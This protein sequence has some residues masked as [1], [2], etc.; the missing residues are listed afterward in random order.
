MHLACLC[1]GQ[2]DWSGFNFTS[3]CLCLT[4]A[5]VN[6]T[7]HRSVAQVN[8]CAR[9]LHR[10]ISQ[11]TG[12]L[13]RSKRVPDLCTGQIHRLMLV[14]DLCTGQFHRSE[15]NSTGQCHFQ[16]LHSAELEII[17][18]CAVFHCHFQ[19]LHSAEFEK[20]ARRAIFHCHFQAFHTCD[21]CTGQLT[22]EIAVTCE[23]NM[24]E[25]SGYLPPT[26]LGAYV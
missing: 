1:T 12:Q 4:C 25:S 15:D 24:H 3:H 21:L 23:M 7:G 26:R 16:V 10:S 22:C 18:P 14:A 17:A 5:Q 19:V 13:H 6:F 20:V 11:V 9:P 2:F 8:A